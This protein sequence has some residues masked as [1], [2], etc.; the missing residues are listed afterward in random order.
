[1]KRAPAIA[2][3]LALATLAV[4]WTAAASGAGGEGNHPRADLSG[5]A[6][7]R[8]VDF[9]TD[10]TECPQAGIRRREKPLR[11]LERDAIERISERGNDIRLNVDYSCFPQ[12][13]TSIAV[14]PRNSRNIAAGANDYRLGWASSGFY[15]STDNGRSWYDGW[16]PFP[17]LPSGDNL[18]GG[19]DPA[20]IYERNGV[21]FWTDIN[22]NRTDDTNGVWTS[23]STNGGFTWSRP[24]V[25]LAPPTGQTESVACGGTGDPRQ[26]GDGTVTFQ[27]DPTPGVLNGDAPF[28]DKEYNDTGPRPAGVAPQ[29]Y[30]PT[31]RTPIPVGAPGCPASRI[32]PDRLYVTWSRF[33]TSGCDEQNE[34]RAPCN[35]RIFES[36]SDDYARSWSAPQPISGS[37]AFCIGIGFLGP[38]ACDD[39]QG[40][41]P[42]VHPKTGV[43][44]VIW[45]NFNTPDENQYL[46]VKSTDG[47]QTWSAPLFVTPVFDVNWPLAG[48]AGG[49]PDCTARGQ[50]AGRRVLTNSCARVNA[51]GAF[52]VDKRGGAYADDLYVVIAD[53]R[54]GTR[55]STN[56][57]VTLYKSTDGGVTWRG[58]TRVND[59]PSAAPANRD[60]GRN[61]GG[62]EE[63]AQPAC[64]TDV[65]TGNDQIFPWIDI[66]ENGDLVVVWQDRRLDQNSTAHE[67]PTSRSRPGNYLLWF[68]GANCEVDSANSSECV[69]P[70]AGTIT[71]PAAPINPPSTTTFPNQTVFPFENFG[72]S[73]TG[74][75]WD[76]CFRAG[77]FCGDYENVFI[78][79]RNRAWAMWTDARNGRSSRAQ[80]GRNPACEQSDVYAEVFRASGRA[81]G[82]N[83]PRATD[84]LFLVSPCPGDAGGGDGGDDDDD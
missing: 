41:Q 25:P 13:E 74:Y 70:T 9:G 32:S 52:V 50:Q 20:V 31:T 73:D 21:V 54:N 51:R 37:A 40:S 33:D 28:E 47:G 14:N 34:F 39:N 46:L 38:N 4:V 27:Q 49:R 53:N 23:R 22:F 43:V 24:C 57:D 83:H 80:Q 18:D 19:G 16:I 10:V 36:H 59:D 67:W 55:I 44:Y 84:Q 5:A 66:G 42:V 64:P 62:P 75:N 82:Q 69:A 61:P 78:D 68:W 81:S 58:P 79:Q 12:N 71:Q 65:H 2:L 48:T 35:V 26:P 63:G 30:T 3:L 76:Y 8:D 45:E 6:E 29:C 77:I 7:L 60:C 17:S 72:I 11:R 15:S 56:T 1:V